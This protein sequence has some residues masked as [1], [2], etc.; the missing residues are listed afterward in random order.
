MHNIQQCVVSISKWHCRGQDNTPFSVLINIQITGKPQGWGRN[1]FG[2]LG[3]GSAT[4]T[5][6]NSP[7]N[8]DNLSSDVRVIAEG[9]DFTCTLLD[10]GAV[11][12]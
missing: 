9:V 3:T 6:N 1:D 7:L 11:K 8:V 10:T 5:A 4:G 2:Q 12:C